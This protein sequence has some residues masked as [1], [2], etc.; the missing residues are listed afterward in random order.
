[1]NRPRILFTQY[2]FIYH[3]SAKGNTQ[4]IEGSY[5]EQCRY[6]KT[7]GTVPSRVYLFVILSFSHS[8]KDRYMHMFINFRQELDIDGILFYSVG[9]Y[10]QFLP[11]VIFQFY[12]L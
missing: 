11:V 8:S 1:M 10:S 7:Y 5:A 12:Y 6:F 9:I 3:C 2:F 4:D